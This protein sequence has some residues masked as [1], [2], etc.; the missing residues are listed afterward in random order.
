MP[1]KLALLEFEI[2]IKP[3]LKIIVDG[4]WAIIQ[5]PWQAR[6]TL[7]DNKSPISEFVTRL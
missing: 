1:D 3:L 5:P 7:L 2:T 4:F 6:D